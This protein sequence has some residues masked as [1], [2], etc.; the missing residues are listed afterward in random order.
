MSM[1]DRYRKTGGLIQLLQL[2]E[3]CDPNKKQK[4]LK[5]IEEEDPLCA[6]TIQ[7]KI[8]T[9]E[10][11][12]SWN[13]NTLLTIFSSIQELTLAIALHGLDQNKQEKLYKTFSHSQLRKIRDLYETKKPTQGEIH[14]A[15]MKIV[16][17]IRNLIKSG[18]LHLDQFDPSLI[19]SEEIEH[20][21][22]NRF[23][24]SKKFIEKD[25]QSAP[26][27]ISSPASKSL[28]K[29]PQSKFTQTNNIE[30]LKHRITEL[31]KEKIQLTEQISHLKEELL[32]YKK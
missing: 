16:E 9:I 21:F 14:T 3:G 29:E 20:D 25:I 5:I 19:I 10:K 2:I 8:I 32:K 7:E 27:K 12:F 18:A 28:Q 15:L 17:E 23:H 31:E 1:I 13:E 6:K 4:F 22:I 26:S 24:A 11:I 30:M